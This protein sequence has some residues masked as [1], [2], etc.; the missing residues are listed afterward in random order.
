MQ[1]PAESYSNSLG[2]STMPEVAKAERVN[3]A[4]Q[5]VLDDPAAP[6]ALQAARP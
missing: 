3:R 5:Q 6:Q 4:F 2:Q 1:V